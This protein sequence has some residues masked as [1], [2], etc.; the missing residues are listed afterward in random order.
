MDKNE[1]EKLR[2]LLNHW[3]EH[4]REH[5]DEFREW[6]ERVR[7]LGGSEVHRDML[8][9]A[10]YMDKASESLSRALTDLGKEKL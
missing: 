7:G 10:Q 8:D 4:N 3:I 1:K 5:G 9:A 6:A 2:I